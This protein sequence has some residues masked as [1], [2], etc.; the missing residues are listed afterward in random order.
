M[1]ATVRKPMPR[2]LV[3]CLTSSVAVLACCLDAAGQEGPGIEPEFIRGDANSDGRVTIHDAIFILEAQ[4]RGGDVPRCDDAADVNDDGGMDLTDVTFF[5]SWLAAIIPDLPAPFPSQGT[6]PTL[7]GLD[8]RDAT[9]VPPTVD[10]AFRMEW[11]HPPRVEPGQRDV[12]VFLLATTAGRTGCFSIAYRVSA[13]HLESLRAD[14]SG[15]DFPEERR[16]S[17][18]SSSLFRVELLP[19]GD[20]DLRLLRIQAIFDDPPGQQIPFAATAGAL[21]REPLLRLVFDVRADAPLDPATAVLAPAEPADIDPLRPAGLN[22]FCQA[23]GA[24]LP[25][26]PAPV[27]VEIAPLPR[28]EFVRGDVNV[29]GRVSPVDVTLLLEVLFFS[30]GGSLDDFR[31]KDAADVNDDGDIAVA[32]AILLLNFIYGLG[33][34]P[35]A[36]FPLSGEDPTPGDA[37]DCGAPGLEPPALDPRYSTA[38]ENAPEVVQ[39]TRDFEMFLTATTDAPI[40]C[41]SIAVRVDRRAATNVRVDFAGTTFPEARREAFEASAFF[42]FELAP[43]DAQLELL[44]AGAT[45]VEQGEAGFQAIDF[46]ATQRPLQGEKLL[47]IVLDVPGDAPVGPVVFLDPVPLDSVPLEAGLYNGFCRRAGSPGAGGGGGAGVEPAEDGGLEEVQPEAGEGSGGIVDGEEYFR[48]DANHDGKIDTSDPI[49]IFSFLF[50]GGGVPAC[51]DA[52]DANSSD[53][54]D[55]SDGVFILGFL[56]SGGEPPAAPFTALGQGVYLGGWAPN[57]PI[58]SC[59]PPGVPGSCGGSE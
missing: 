21:T 22:E 19:L 1:I 52:A 50:L 59:D 20:P 45:F 41:F 54:L 43:I 47:R 15:T 11:S 24:V 51:C 13:R 27:T 33:G 5:L 4:F 25:Q 38:W 37:L 57:L 7:D 32:D 58:A 34:A 6:D 3:R 31:C 49:T 44:T 29:S 26:D 14:F 30:P 8:C 53:E 16:A 42:G 2:C 12:E 48:G 35:A 39:G 10:A 40:E 55:I 28:P 46:A 36:P 9:V 17:F 18:E 23:G 56:F